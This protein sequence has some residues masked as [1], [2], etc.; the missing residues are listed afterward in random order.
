MQQMTKFINNRRETETKFGTTKKYR[1][2]Q[3]FF[4]VEKIALSDLIKKNLNCCFNE[5]IMTRR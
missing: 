3:F 1:F 5:I 4:V 2:F